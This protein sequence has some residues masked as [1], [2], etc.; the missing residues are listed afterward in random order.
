[1]PGIAKLLFLGGEQFGAPF[2]LG[3]IPLGNQN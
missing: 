1:M 3:L 2:Y